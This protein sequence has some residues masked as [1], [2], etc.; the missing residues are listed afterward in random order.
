MARVEI[1][2]TAIAISLIITTG[3]V[4][5]SLNDVD[6]TQDIVRAEVGTGKQV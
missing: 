1:N 2:L 6:S 3:G 4:N 5:A